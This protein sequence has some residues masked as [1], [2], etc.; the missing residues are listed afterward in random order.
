MVRLLNAYHVFCLLLALTSGDYS[1]NMGHLLIIVQ[2]TTYTDCL[3]LCRQ[4]RV[5]QCTWNVQSNSKTFSTSLKYHKESARR[6]T[7]NWTSTY[8]LV[9]E[10]SR[11]IKVWVMKYVLT[12]LNLKVASFNTFSSPCRAIILCFLAMKKDYCSHW[13]ELWTL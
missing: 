10:V 1:Y 13:A 8:V 7:T 9:S 11:V 4:R 2:V 12:M 3:I 5:R 6:A